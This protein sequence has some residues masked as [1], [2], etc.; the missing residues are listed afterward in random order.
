MS[1]EVQAVFQLSS[2][3]QMAPFPGHPRTL[4]NR[5]APTRGRTFLAG[6]AVGQSREHP[7]AISILLATA[8]VSSARAAGT[9]C[10]LPLVPRGMC[11]STA[12]AP[13]LVYQHYPPRPSSSPPALSMWHH[14]IQGTAAAGTASHWELFA[15]QPLVLRMVASGMIVFL[16]SVSESDATYSPGDKRQET[17][18]SSRAHLCCLRQLDQE[19]FLVPF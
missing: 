12:A 5:L 18:P 15:P 1:K 2:Q 11:P 17:R 8:K 9:T 10:H 4:A 7:V 19:C 3:P 6:L 16:L 13:A 14:C